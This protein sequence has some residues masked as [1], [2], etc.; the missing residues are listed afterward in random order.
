M[1]MVTA[2]D[3][4]IGNITD[5]LREANMEDN[6]LIIF[7]T[8]NGGTDFR[9][10][11]SNLPLRGT[12][13]KEFHKS[14]LLCRIILQGTLWEGGTRGAAFIHGS[15]LKRPGTLSR[16]LIHVSDWLPTLISAAGG[17]IHTMIEDGDNIDGVNQWEELRDGLG[18]NKRRL[19]LYN[20]DPLRDP[21]H[22]GNGAIR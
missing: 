14:L 16:S 18:S 7:T 19:M 21:S 12:K 6:T 17:D 3:E 4:A 2:M 10:G 20:I 15:M 22:G 13:V 8:D 9:S 5:T 1:G 11:G